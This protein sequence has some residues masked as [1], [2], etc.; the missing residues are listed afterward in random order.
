[1]NNE[2]K[3]RRS[4]SSSSSSSIPAVFVPLLLPLVV[5]VGLVALN[6]NSGATTTMTTVDNARGEQGG[7]GLAAFSNTYELKASWKVS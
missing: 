6:A 5:A 7:G 1:M 4:D 3:R 2:N